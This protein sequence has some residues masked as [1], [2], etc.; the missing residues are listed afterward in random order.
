MR[1]FRRVRRDDRGRRRES[2]CHYLEFRDADGIERRVRAVEDRG[3]SEALGRRIERLVRLRLEH[4]KPEAELVRWIPEHVRRELLRIGLL[5]AAPAAR[6]T[7]LAELLAEFKL[8]LETRDR[9]PAWVR[10]VVARAEET[11]TGSG[12][13]TLADVEPD[14]VERHLKAERDRGR[15]ARESNHRLH[16]CREF[17]RWAVGRGLVQRDPLATV[18]PVNARLDPRHV[19][20]ALGEDEL[21]KLI[22][23]AYESPTWRAV[24]G[25]TRALAWRLAAQAGLRIGEIHALQVRDVELDAQGGPQLVVRAAVS[26]NRTEARLPLSPELARD[27]QPLTRGKL[28]TASLLEL[29]PAFKDH[30]PRWLRFDLARAGIPYADATGRVA[31]VHALRSAF[32]TSLMRSGANVKAIQVLAR[33][34]DPRLTVGLYSRFDPK[35]ARDALSRAPDLSPSAGEQRATGTDGWTAKGTGPGSEPFGSVHSLAHSNPPHGSE[36]AACAPGMVETKGVEPSTSA[37]RTQRS[38]S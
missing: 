22:Q 21:R 11:L 10:R 37:L 20:R 24:S 36:K 28:P 30:A 12:F 6:A 14:A 5:D 34:S 23:V 29:P 19:R 7:P 26:K 3:A 9:T 2:A 8:T 16:A 33:H 32:V 27:L 1:V 13:V 18:Q 17:M 25:P 15:S 38:T 4:E 35:D 31:D